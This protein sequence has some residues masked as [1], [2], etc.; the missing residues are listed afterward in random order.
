MPA[1]RGRTDNAPHV[2]GRRERVP[3]HRFLCLIGPVQDQNCP[4]RL[5]GEARRQRVPP[6]QLGA[7]VCRKVLRDASPSQRRV[8]EL[9]RP[10]PRSDLDAQRRQDCALAAPR[11]AEESQDAG[12][13]AR[14]GGVSREAVDGIKLRLERGQAPDLGCDELLVFLRVSQAPPEVRG[15]RQGTGRTR[16]GKQRC[17]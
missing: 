5:L 17:V 9:V 12:G 4:G 1:L 6:A 2:R 13:S 16:G 15:R 8:A 7:Q 10:A 14:G 11:G 3:H